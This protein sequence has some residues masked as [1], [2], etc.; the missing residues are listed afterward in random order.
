MV[1]LRALGLLRNREGKQKENSNETVHH[2]GRASVGEAVLWGLDVAERA[3][4]EVCE[5][6]EARARGAKAVQS[7]RSEMCHAISAR[8]RSYCAK[9][10]AAAARSLCIC[11]AL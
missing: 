9:S 2:S 5:R 3:K 11:L 10:E 7:Y 6:G 8:S 4:S 1:L